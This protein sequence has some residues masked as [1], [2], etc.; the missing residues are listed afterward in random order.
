MELAAATNVRVIVAEAVIEYREIAK[1]V[2]EATLVQSA[3]KCAPVR[4]NLPVVFMLILLDL[5]VLSVKM[6]ITA[7]VN[8][9]NV[10]SDVQETATRD[11]VTSMGLVMYVKKDFMGRIVRHAPKIAMIPAIQM[12]YATPAYKVT[13]DLN[14][15]YHV[16]QTALDPVGKQMVC[17]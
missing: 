1:H 15:H 6:T 2:V 8:L 12:A 13:M 11:V 16:L 9:K 5:S 4:V 14:V 7:A 3:I 17:A 10:A